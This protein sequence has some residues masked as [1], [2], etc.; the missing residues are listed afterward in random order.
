MKRFNIFKTFKKHPVKG[1]T[2]RSSSPRRI[3]SLF[4]RRRSR[5]CQNN[6][7]IPYDHE[8]FNGSS[9][10]EQ[11]NGDKYTSIY[12]SNY[13]P[14]R[15]TATTQSPKQVIH[16]NPSDLTI[17]MHS[18]LNNKNQIV[19]E[20]LKKDET[21]P[22][23]S[24]VVA[25]NMSQYESF[26]T[27]LDDEEL[28]FH[29][30][31]SR[32]DNLETEPITKPTF[33]TKLTATA[34]I[35][36][37]LT[38]SSKDTYDS[39]ISSKSSWSKASTNSSIPQ[40]CDAIKVVKNYYRGRDST[41]SSQNKK[42]ISPQQ[43]NHNIV[44]NMHLNHDTVNNSE[45]YLEHEHD[46][47][48]CMDHKDTALILEYIKRIGYVRLF[49]DGIKGKNRT[50]LVTDKPVV[51]VTDTAQVEEQLE[52]NDVKQETLVATK[53]K[54]SKILS[55]IVSRSRTYK[56]RNESTSKRNNT[57]SPMKRMK[58]SIKKGL[59]SRT[60]SSTSSKWNLERKEIQAAS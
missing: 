48:R 21:L 3:T 45:N 15:R 8:S 11:Q 46:D 50:I 57:L 36:N 19:S 32:E 1:E 41:S 2:K 27:S 13:P 17:P 18:K 55:K 7:L 14:T 34:T 25:T 30:Q 20:A 4:K 12:E 5:Y 26:Y 6:T 51:Q 47:A 42:T 9:Y 58:Q 40:C 35:S 53:D 28:T 39:I 23:V 24:Q 33:A 44:Q 52:C 60:K 56:K 10:E 37:D 29:T 38:S 49:M 31:P 22:P 59:S 43:T 16:Y 54:D